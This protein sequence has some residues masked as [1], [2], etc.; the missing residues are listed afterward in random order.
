MK[1]W[2]GAEPKKVK[3][4]YLGLSGSRPTPAMRSQLSL[5][6]GVG[7]VVEVVE[8]DSPAARAG[9]N[10]YDVLH[11]LNDQILVNLE[12]LAILVRTFKPGDEVA[13][14]VLRQSK[15]KT[16]KVKLI[17]KEVYDLDYAEMLGA[18][19]NTQTLNLV[20]LAPVPAAGGVGGIGPFPYGFGGVSG[21]IAAYDGEY[22][23]EITLDKGKHLLVVTDKNGKQV[24]QGPVTTE[25]DMKAVPEAIRRRLAKVRAVIVTGDRSV[26]ASSDAVDE[27]SPKIEPPVRAVE[28]P[29][30][31]PRR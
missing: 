13:L 4:A 22:K 3:A 29:Q 8:Q 26:S 9:V 1:G 16:L 23:L 30:A 11:K 5:P 21:G 27:P 14:T 12:Q 31:A 6:A 18:A 19:G 24:F 20:G 17:E 25:A 15:P 7:L 2:F 10:Q 28:P